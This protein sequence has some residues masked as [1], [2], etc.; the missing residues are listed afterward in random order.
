MF[1]I[2][3][4]KKRGSQEFVS[5]TLFLLGHSNPVVELLAL[6][7]KGLSSGGTKLDEGKIKC[8]SPAMDRAH[9]LQEAKD[10]I[11]NDFGPSP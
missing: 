10:K 3:C 6:I 1:S 7:P 2:R 8:L 9:I 4:T 11:W 5:R